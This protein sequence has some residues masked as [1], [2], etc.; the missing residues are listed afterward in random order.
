MFCL[1]LLA[2]PYRLIS[3]GTAK[4]PIQSY[5]RRIDRCSI[6]WA[7]TSL[8]QS[9]SRRSSRAFLRGPRQPWRSRSEMVERR[10]WAFDGEVVER[11]R[12]ERVGRRLTKAQKESGAYHLAFFIGFYSDL[13]YLGRI[14]RPGPPSLICILRYSSTP[15][16]GGSQGKLRS[17]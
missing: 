5:A 8:A 16:E 9:R 7:A 3:Y 4:R 2:Y 17:L 10:R 13:D 15:T 11:G 1:A 12:L 14:L 6:R